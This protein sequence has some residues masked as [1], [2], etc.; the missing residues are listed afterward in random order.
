MIIPFCCLLSLLTLLT[1]HN[2]SLFHCFIKCG[3]TCHVTVLLCYCV[4]S[5]FLLMLR[6]FAVSLSTLISLNV[7]PLCRYVIVL[8]CYRMLRFCVCVVYENS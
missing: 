2:V 7:M 5:R 1:K 8:S 4:S 3:S 6:C